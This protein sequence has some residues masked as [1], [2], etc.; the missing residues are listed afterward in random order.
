M[1]RH[2]L[3][4]SLTAALNDLPPDTRQ[5]ILAKF[6]A[7]VLKR[8]ARQAKLERARKMKAAKVPYD[9]ICR[10]L[11]LSKRTVAAL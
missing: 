10:E 8:D 4:E 11:S 6:V 3:T 2:I 9:T 5:R 1:N 7:E